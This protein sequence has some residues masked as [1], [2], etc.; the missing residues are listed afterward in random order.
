MGGLADRRRAGPTTCRRFS[1]A[2]GGFNRR[3]AFHPIGAMQNQS[4]FEF[5]VIQVNHGNA[6]FMQRQQKGQPV[7]TGEL[8]RKT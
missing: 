1:V 2:G 7:N 6:I 5:V 8:C 3:R 4:H